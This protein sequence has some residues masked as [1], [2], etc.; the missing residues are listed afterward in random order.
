[1]KLSTRPSAPMTPNLEQ[2][3][4]PPL[5]RALEQ[6]YTQLPLHHRLN[7]SKFLREHSTKTF[8]LGSA[9]SGTDLIFKCFE[10][11][12]ANWQALFGTTLSTCEAFAVE[13]APDKQEFLT[14]NHVNT[15]ALFTSVED[16]MCWQ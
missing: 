9:C 15:K 10:L 1:M 16:M 7:T 5:M 6:Y 2:S 11:L 3:A 14:R 4:A 12:N 13:H 8:V